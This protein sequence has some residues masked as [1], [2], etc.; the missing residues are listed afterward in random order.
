MMAMM[1]K[2]RVM[3][4]QAKYAESLQCYQTVLERAPDI[5][6]PDPRIG[7]GCCLWQLD[8]KDDARTAWQR[9]LELVGYLIL[10]VGF[11]N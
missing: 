4:S 3:F 2:A 1:G 10:K 11:Y 8:H 7:I 9:A 5:M 6:D